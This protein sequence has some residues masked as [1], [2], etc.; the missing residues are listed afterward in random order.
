MRCLRHVYGSV[1]PLPPCRGGGQGESGGAPKRLKTPR[2]GLPPGKAADPKEPKVKVVA[3]GARHSL[4]L[5]L[6]GVLFAW[7]HGARLGAPGWDLRADASVPV[8]VNGSGTRLEGVNIASISAGAAHSALVDIQGRMYT[9]GEARGNAL[10]F[11]DGADRPEPAAV[12]CLNGPAFALGDRVGD[13]GELERIVAQ[14]RQRAREAEEAAR[15]GRKARHEPCGGCSERGWHSGS[16][17][18]ARRRD[19]LARGGG[20]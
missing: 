19:R 8:R 15:G 20:S 6:D 10:G 3:A 18:R 1:S 4:A 11:F 13:R 2:G 16:D 12:D 17:G 7:G 5:T 14:A 9:W